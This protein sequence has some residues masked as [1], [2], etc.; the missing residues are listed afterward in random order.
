MQASEGMWV[1][2]ERTSRG[3]LTR[4]K[5]Q[6]WQ[7]TLGPGG[8]ELAGLGKSR[9]RVSNVQAS[10]CG[11]WVSVQVAQ[12]LGSRPGSCPHPFPCP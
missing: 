9:G 12:P 4:G 5:T 1:L 3:C 6:P 7:G 10:G 2:G 11:N 8:W